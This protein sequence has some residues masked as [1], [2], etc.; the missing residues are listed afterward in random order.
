MSPRSS[1]SRHDR[2]TRI[3]WRLAG[4]AGETVSHVLAGLVL[5]WGVSKLLDNETWILVGGLTG[6][7]TGIAALVRGALKLN[8][9]M[10]QMAGV[11]GRAKAEA[12]DSP[13]SS[14]DEKAGS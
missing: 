3:G 11:G 7:V 1:E 10:D 6:V 14:D 12:G 8:A 2:D 4:L 9:Q 5:G 13:P